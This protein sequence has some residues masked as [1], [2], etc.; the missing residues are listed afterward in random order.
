MILGL[1][2]ILYFYFSKINNEFEYIVSMLNCAWQQFRADFWPGFWGDISTRCHLDRRLEIYISMRIEICMY[3]AICGYIEGHRRNIYIYI[4]IYIKIYIYI[5]IYIQEEGKW[6]WR[7]MNYE[8][9]RSSR[10]A[11]Y[12]ISS[13]IPMHVLK[14]KHIGWCLHNCGL[15]I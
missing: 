8:Y 7:V 9:H 4:Y 2:F 15:W 13:Y 10:S 11:K 12:R 3:I 5:Y 14:C 6:T 1:T